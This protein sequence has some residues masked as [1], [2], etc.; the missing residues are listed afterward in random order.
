MNARLDEMGLFETLL[1]RLILAFAAISLLI[2]TLGQYAVATF[3]AARRTRDFGVRLALGASTSQVQFFVLREALRLVVPALVIGFMLS[4]VLATVF[5]SVLLDVSPTDP[6]IYGGVA[7]LLTLSSL[8][9][10]F[11]PAWRAGRINV[12]EVLRQ[13]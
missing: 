8:A 3:N 10:S 4:G 1:T 12:V 6:V 2:A 11:M 7:L 9:A 5:R 13:E